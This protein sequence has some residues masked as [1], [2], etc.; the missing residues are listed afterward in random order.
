MYISD[1]FM[2]KDIPFPEP[3]GCESRYCAANR[4]SS[5]FMFDDFRRKEIELEATNKNSPK[6]KQYLDALMISQCNV[7]ER[8]RIGSFRIAIKTKNKLTTHHHHHRRHDGVIQ[9]TDIRNSKKIAV[10]VFRKPSF[11][12]FS[13]IRYFFAVLSLF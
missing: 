10:V 9:H 2:T 5:M 3:F 8:I 7:A 11:I 13:L 1:M 4:S 6:Q 12:I